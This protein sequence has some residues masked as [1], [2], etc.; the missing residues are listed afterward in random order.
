MAKKI[1]F[2]PSLFTAQTEAH[3]ANV[4]VDQVEDVGTENILQ[5]FIGEE[6]ER[7]E[8]T[9]AHKV[10]VDSIL[11]SNDTDLVTLADVAKDSIF[12]ETDL[13]DAEDFI[14]DAIASIANMCEVSTSLKDDLVSEDEEVRMDA[15]EEFRDI[16][17]DSM[18]SVEMDSLTLSTILYNQD[19]IA[20]SIGV[21]M[22]DITFDETWYK[23]HTLCKGG[24]DGKHPLPSHMKC[25]ESSKNGKSG[26]RRVSKTGNHATGDNKAS[27]DQI[28]HTTEMGKDTMLSDSKKKMIKSLKATNKRKKKAKEKNA[29]SVRSIKRVMNK[30]NPSRGR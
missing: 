20:D 10:V 29:K 7:F 26:E 9:L 19:V 25:T 16:L 2:D 8:E 4:V 1:T 11:S 23:N 14:Y 13:E 6:T 15:L 21:E 18:A 17:S 28:E 30:K 5:D 3:G 12:G 27:D 22:D 24:A